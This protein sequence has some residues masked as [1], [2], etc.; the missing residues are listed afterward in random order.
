MRSVAILVD[1]SNMHATFKALGFNIDWKKVLATV[2]EDIPVHRAVYFTAL[3]PSHITSSIRPL[4]DYLQFNGWSVEHKP[5]SQYKDTNGVTKVKGNMDVEIAVCAMQLQER[6]TDVMLFTGDG[7]FT[8]LVKAL[9]QKG[10]RVT[11]VSTRSTRPA[12]ASD[13][14]VRTADVFVDLQDMKHCI[15]RDTA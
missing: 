14:L 12:M 4:I 2:E 10:I 5:V 15:L 3:Y 1:G 8:A 6:V 11:V 13:L 9:Q 7:D